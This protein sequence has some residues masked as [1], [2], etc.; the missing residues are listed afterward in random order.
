MSSIHIAANKGQIA[1][2]VLLPGD[3]LRAESIAKSFFKKV[4]KYNAI[5]NMLG[6]TGTAPDGRKVSVQG[7]GMGMPSLAIYVNE[8]IRTYGVKR[9]IRVGSCGSMQAEVKLKDIVLALGACSDSA[10]NKRRFAGMDFAPVADWEL[11]HKAYT[12]AKAF[13]IPVHIGN[14]FATDKFYDDI[15]PEAWKIFARYGVLAVEMETAELY[16]LAAQKEVQAL[17]ILTVSD[18]LITRNHLNAKEREQSFTDMVK[19][20]LQL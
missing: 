10:M 13:S 7:A 9:I 12:T 17:T 15:D 19:I 11:L 5:R 2:T 1:E 3:P 8:L 6:F 20:A 4:R 14:I 16:T 18:S